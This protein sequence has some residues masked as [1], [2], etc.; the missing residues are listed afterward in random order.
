MY[1]VPFYEG[2]HNEM[3][4]LPQYAQVRNPYPYSED[5]IPWLE[6]TNWEVGVPSA[7][8][9]Q[10]G[11]RKRMRR[12]AC[13]LAPGN[14]PFKFILSLFLSAQTSVLPVTVV[15][16]FI[17]F[18]PKQLIWNGVCRRQGFFIFY[19]MILVKWKFWNFKEMI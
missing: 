19:V 11:E 13:V 10:P 9:Y 15:C 2:T 1:P 18:P 17:C 5:R 7:S 12:H 3:R 16:L 8:Q 14:V 4:E 6:S